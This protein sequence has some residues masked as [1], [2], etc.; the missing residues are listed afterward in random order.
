M[1]PH[2]PYTVIIFSRYFLIAFN[3]VISLVVISVT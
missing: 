2:L 3:I 1:F